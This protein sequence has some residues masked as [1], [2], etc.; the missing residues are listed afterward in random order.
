MDVYNWGNPYVA[1]R[2]FKIIDMSKELLFIE[3]TEGDISNIVI[4]INYL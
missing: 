1:F 4:K 2:R 3:A